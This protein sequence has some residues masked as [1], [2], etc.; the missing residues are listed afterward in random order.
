MYLKT[1]T[2]HGFKS[3]AHPVQVALGPGLNAVVGP[4][5]SGKSNLIDALRWVLGERRGGHQVLFHG[6]EKYRP[7][8]MASVELF[9]E[10]P[11][12][13]EKRAFASGEV[14]YFFQGRKVR[15]ADLRQELAK[16]GLSLSRSEIGFVTN[17]DLH[18]LADLS[19]LERLRWLEE[20][21]GALAM[22]A[23]LAELSRMLQGVVEK[24]ERFRERLR[25]IAFQRARVAE[26]AKKEEEYLHREKR[27]KDARKTYYVRLLEK[28]RED[29]VRL[30]E[31][32]SLCEREL[33]RL[34]N[35]R[36]LLALEADERNL[37]TLRNTLSSLR[38]EVEEAQKR[39]REKEQELYQLLTE[40]RH[41]R[42]LYVALENRGKSLLEQLR[43]LERENGHL[44]VSP[45]A[46][47]RLERTESVVVRFLGEKKVQLKSLRERERE[48]REEV[49]RFETML[50]STEQEL[51]HL[52]VQHGEL[53]R[54]IGDL[55]KLLADAAERRK[56]YEN[57]TKVLE[58]E[59]E[60]VQHRLT[61]TEE[62]LA[63]L[64]RALGRVEFQ[65]VPEVISEAIRADL[66][67]KGWPSRAIHA[68]FG[69]LKS[70]RVLEKE[71]IPENPGEW[72]AFRLAL[73][74]CSPEWTVEK[75]ETLLV[76]LREGKELRKNCIALDGSLVALKGGLFLLPRKVVAGTRF[77][78][79]WR[80]RESRFACRV[81]ELERMLQEISSRIEEV[82]KRKRETELRVVQWQERLRQR[83]E[84]R[85]EI[86]R[87]I[88]FLS[89]ERVR[90]LR[91]LAEATGKVQEISQ[92]TGALQRMISRAEKTLEKVEEK[93]KQRE[94]AQRRYERF[95]WEVQRIREETLSVIAGMRKATE[96]LWLFGGRLMRCGEELG[97]LLSEVAAKE[98]W[99]RE[100]EKEEHSLAKSLEMKR[101]KERALEREREKWV[102]EKER[103][104]F[105]RERLRADIERTENLLATLDGLVCPEWQAMDLEDLGRFVEEEERAL[106]RLPVRRGALE[107]YAEL[108]S[109]E[110]HLAR[111]DALFEE[112]ITLV[113]LEC[114]G[115]ERDIRRQFLTFVSR[116]K[117][118]FSQYFQRIFRGGQATLVVQD[119]GAH[120][121]VEIP[122]KK[123]QSVALL[124]SGERTL[125]ALCFLCACFEAGDAKMCFFDEVDANLDH[126][127]SVLLAQV[128]KE[129]AAKR[130]VVVVTHKEE[131]MEVADRILGVTMNEPGVSQVL[132][133][134][135]F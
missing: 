60:M 132:L 47:A 67:K 134:E 38:R 107:E 90:L 124:S 101:Q 1:L 57:E 12:R 88:A 103:I 129:F 27:W 80:K 23:R 51:K 79:S 114:K 91:C 98:V 126:T 125:V 18:A 112:L 94:L 118:A 123:K 19:P 35:E 108:Q 3:F 17:R 30:S 13:V 102:R 54:E 50:K 65:G 75:R 58:K 2:L 96:N 95:L 46:S 135:R 81:Q 78:E 62:V 73:P 109:R 56:A 6:S 119:G 105:A 76:D 24:R 52:R 22:R 127:N 42:K 29:A 25:E 41:E 39:V 66:L 100:K 16:A 74:P 113:S 92:E 32:A 34:L 104:R 115:L 37:L 8:G 28:L 86:A 89:A 55:E 77:I 4:N 85:E 99:L 44:R 15:L 111:Q 70:V 40:M 97:K 43:R 128:L 72:M 82:E 63:C 7:V 11:L 45:E 110:E 53:T 14:E 116:A 68:F 117:D 131:V 71:E 122:G 83:G 59:K 20:T 36:S 5:G 9:F 33:H 120:L 26:W 130:Q 49:V 121:E 106:L 64:R 31:E 84:V 21:S 61:R 87:K 133:C 93:K 69:F 10:P 48:L